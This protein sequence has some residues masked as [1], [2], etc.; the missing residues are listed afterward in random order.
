[1]SAWSKVDPAIAPFL[2]WWV[3][4][5]AEIG[6]YPSQIKGRVCTIFAIPTGEFFF[7]LGSEFNGY[8]RINEGRLGR[9]VLINQRNGNFNHLLIAHVYRNR[10]IAQA[11]SDIY[12]YPQLL[13]APANLLRE[14]QKDKSR[15]IQEFHTAGCTASLTNIPK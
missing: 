14:N 5:D 4:N 7:S 11:G 12:A 15:I 6:V 9:H 13:I 10:A 8:I 3:N 1:V 2:G